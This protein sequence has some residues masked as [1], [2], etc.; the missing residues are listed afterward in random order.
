MNNLL[1]TVKWAG[2]VVF[3][4]SELIVTCSPGVR[5]LVEQSAVVQ[6]DLLLYVVAASLL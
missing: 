6:R 1:D 4:N 2:I 5:D 3:Q